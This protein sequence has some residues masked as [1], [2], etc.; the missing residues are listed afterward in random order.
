[1]RDGEAPRRE[2]GLFIWTI[3]ILLLIGG[4]ISCWIFSFYIFGHPEKAMSYS[5]LTKLKKLD[6]PK[7]FEL[8]AAPRGEFLGPKSLWE[9]YSRMSDRELQRH[10]EVLLRNYLRNYKL[11]QELVPYV[12]GSY[13][14]LDSYEL[15]EQNAFPTGVVALAQAAEN[16]QIVLEQVFPADPRVV[17]VLQRMLLTGLELR[18]DKTVDL[19]ALVN[20]TRR[21]DGVLQFTA[22]PLLYGSYASSVG[23]GTFSLDPPDHLNI[24][25]GLPVVKAD[26]VDEAQQKLAA[27]RMRLG[28]NAKGK[29]DS[30]KPT[31]PQLVRVERPKMPETAA[32]TPAPSATPAP[33]PV[34]ARPV[35]T[36]P[37]PVIAEATPPPA[38]PSPTPA[39]DQPPLQAF[40]GTTTEP[41]SIANTSG[42]AWPT[43]APGQMPRGRLANVPDMEELATRGVSG[44][45]IY[46]QGNFVVT[47]AGQNRAVLRSQSPTENLGVGRSTSK[48]RVIVE[49]PTSSRP[50]QEGSTFSRD[51]RR[52]FLITDV[53][54]G[55][56]GQVNVYVREVTRA[57]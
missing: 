7:R 41:A 3:I 5:I 11:T 8:T 4:A 38:T 21:K 39:D 14:I 29:D 35:T 31:A 16:P 32:A 6:A 57:Q 15:T 27:Y 42:G 23:S 34:A 33:T 55:A 24:A 40:T 12:V 28:L 1:M 10:S 49:F 37:T 30:K 48:T 54:K 13:N 9:R 2:G 50:P 22:L 53:R 52:P 47:A 20:V 18:L 44:E 17:P 46:L 36:K 25:A 43:Y 19:S 56:D 26:A 51:S 45:R